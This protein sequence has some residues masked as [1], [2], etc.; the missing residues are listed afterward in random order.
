MYFYKTKIVKFISN[1]LRFSF[2]IN[3]TKYCRFTNIMSW[4][5]IRKCIIYYIKN[6]EFNFNNIRCDD[7]YFI[8]KLLQ[9]DYEKI[10]DIL[11]K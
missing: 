3:Q 7:K 9:F 10:S 1:I 6:Y 4:Q 8:L 5:R 2:I 11:L